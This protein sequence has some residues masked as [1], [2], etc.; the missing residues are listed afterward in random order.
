MNGALVLLKGNSG[1]GVRP[2][3]DWGTR[4]LLEKHLT[5]SFGFHK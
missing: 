5:D 2:V 3:L 4:D 1:D